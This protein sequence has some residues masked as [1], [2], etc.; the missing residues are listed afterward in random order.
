MKKPVAKK[1]HAQSKKRPSTRPSVRTAISSRNRF[2]LREDAAGYTTSRSTGLQTRKSP[3]SADLLTKAEQG[4][5]ARCEDTIRHGW[6]SFVNVGEALVTIR[7]KQ[8]FRNRY[9][10]FEDYYRAEWQYQKSQVYRLM[11]AAKVVRVLS[12]IGET[13]SSDLPLP[14]CEAQVRSLVGLKESEIKNVWRQVAKKADG[15][16]ITARLVQ[17][18]VRAIAPTP[19]KAGGPTKRRHTLNGSDQIS[20]IEKAL[21]QLVDMVGQDKG[22]RETAEKLQQQI[23]HF[24]RNH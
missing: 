9:E 1:P 22:K 14:T 11:E 17:S 6:Q 15:K 13:S 21:G 10:R 8:L 18:H 24:F 12:P 5:F 7:D 20:V 3:E 23:L 19:Q 4:E 2:S 16:R